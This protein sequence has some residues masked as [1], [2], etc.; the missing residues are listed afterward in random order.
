MT[1]MMIN[2]SFKDDDVEVNKRIWSNHKPAISALV[3]MDISRWQSNAVQILLI[4]SC[5]QLWA[6]FAGMNSNAV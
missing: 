5:N 2:L 3:T 4:A 6:S 1:T